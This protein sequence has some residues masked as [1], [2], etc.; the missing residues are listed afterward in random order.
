MSYDLG[1]NDVVKKHLIL[2]A[3]IKLAI[4]VTRH[5]K[6]GF[7]AG[8]GKFFNYTLNIE[9]EY[10]ATW[11]VID[12]KNK[13]RIFQNIVELKRTL[14]ILKCLLTKTEMKC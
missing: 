1:L 8:T 2:F 12:C 3:I 5:S 7:V 13:G 6:G 4:N 11:P 9:L 14:L 10:Q